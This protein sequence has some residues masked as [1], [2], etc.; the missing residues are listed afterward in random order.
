MVWNPFRRRPKQ[1]PVVQPR[2]GE[3]LTR[4]DMRTLE[5][6]ATPKETP[7]K[8][9]PLP[10]QMIGPNE[11]IFLGRQ[12]TSE[13]FTAQCTRLGWDPQKAFGQMFASFKNPPDATWMRARGYFNAEWEK[14]E[15][16]DRSIDGARLQLERFFAEMLKTKRKQ[17]KI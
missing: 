12:V 9:G 1:A 15:V 14:V 11:Q 5:R 13:A 10:S 17:R 8:L 6:S 2:K 16:K 7:E 3:E 4:R